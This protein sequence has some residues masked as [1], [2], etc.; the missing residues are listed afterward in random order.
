MPLK[1]GPIDIL[2]FPANSSKKIDSPILCF[3]F[4]V[5]SKSCKGNGHLNYPSFIKDSGFSVH[6][7]FPIG[8][9]SS[10]IIGNVKIF[11][12]TVNI[13]KKYESTLSII[14]CVQR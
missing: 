6:N 9:V 12:S 10:T 2:G 11:N 13:K 3:Q 8:V 14:K 5:K 1:R 7:S 4:H